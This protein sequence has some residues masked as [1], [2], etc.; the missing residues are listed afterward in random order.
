M[1]FSLGFT[2]KWITMF[3]FIFKIQRMQEMLAKMQAQL[4]TSPRTAVN[5]T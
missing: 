4:Q 3:D 5:G 1:Q 2:N